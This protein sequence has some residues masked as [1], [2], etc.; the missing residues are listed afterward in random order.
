MTRG[1]LLVVFAKRPEAGLVKTRLCPPFTPEQAAAFYARLLA[2]VLDA[3]VSAAE[4]LGLTLRLAIHPASG[5][6]DPGVEVPARVQRVAQVGADLSERMEAA[7][8]AAGQEGYGPILI[9]GSDSPALGQVPLARALAALEQVDVVVCPDVDGGYNLVGARRAVA[10]LFDHE[11]STADVLRQTV[12][13]ARGLGLQ[14]ALLPR[15]FDI[16]TAADLRL[17]RDSPEAMR[18]CSRTC[19]Y[20]DEHGLWPGSR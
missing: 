12:E 16:D 20:L 11:M 5:V 18:T 9:R 8:Q 14:V 3:S 17:L 1:P 19:A 6:E 7:M 4:A 13:R 10:G 2:D 15:G